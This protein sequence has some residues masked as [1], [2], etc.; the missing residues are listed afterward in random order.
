[1]LD[2]ELAVTGASVGVAGV[3]PG[4]DGLPVPPGRRAPGR[5]AW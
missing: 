5:R 3:V 4:V 1:M 2:D